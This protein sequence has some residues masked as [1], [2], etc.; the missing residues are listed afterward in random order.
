MES[1]DQTEKP[2]ARRN[3]WKIGFFVALLAFE[4]TRE[5]AV[6][7]G[8]AEAQPNAYFSMFNA[9]TFATAEGSWKRIDGGEKLMPTTVRI[10]CWRD[11]GSCI[12]AYSSVMNGY[13]YPPDIDYF[14]AKFDGDAITYDN[15]SPKCASY[16]VRLD[17]KLK[18]VIAVRTKKPDAPKPDCNVLSDGRVEM[19]LAN[20]YEY[21]NPAEGHFVP[22]ISA[23]GAILGW[24]QK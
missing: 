18:K 20:S 21:R 24:F 3:W 15:Q 4:V 5:I 10:Q 13:F 6:I 12:E 9:G 2:K 7:E 14:D 17:F 8:S 22:V 19:Q 16:S 1:S 11:Q 23:L